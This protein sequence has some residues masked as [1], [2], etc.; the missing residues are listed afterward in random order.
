LHFHSSP[1]EVLSNKEIA[2]LVAAT[3]PVLTASKVKSKDS[4]KRILTSLSRD[5]IFNAIA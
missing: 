3:V 4:A 5:E 2:A 1:A